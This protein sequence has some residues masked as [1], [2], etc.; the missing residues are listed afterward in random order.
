M[1][2]ANP[3]STY[4]VSILLPILGIIIV[5]LR[6]YTRV[7]QRMSLGIDDWLVV[8]ALVRTVDRSMISDQ[9]C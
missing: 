8:P 1:P 2:Y 4:T 6:V 5:G 7:L 3:A 9:V